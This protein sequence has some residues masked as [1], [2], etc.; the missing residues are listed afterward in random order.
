MDGPRLAAQLAFLAESELLKQVERRTMVGEGSTRRR[1]NSAEHSWSLALFALVLAEHADEPVDLARVL[2]LCLV[3]DLVEID[4]GDTFAYDTR[5]HEDKAA[6]EQAAA[7][8]IFGLLPPDQAA[9]VRDAW[10]EFE[11]AL[12]PE[13]RFAAAVDRLQPVLLNVADR[14]GTWAEHQLRLAQVMARNEPISRGSATLWAA[15]R[16]RIEA[17]VDAGWLR[18]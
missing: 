11:A 1:E 18:P 4:A 14:G 5:A 17:G 10:E 6:R 16:R 3:H 7:E 8:R 9:F 13:A 15:A 12:T 2:T